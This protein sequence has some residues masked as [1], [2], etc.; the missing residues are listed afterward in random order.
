M[1]AKPKRNAV[2]LLGRCA[3]K[4]NT[5]QRWTITKRKCF[6]VV[7]EYKT[8]TLDLQSCDFEKYFQECEE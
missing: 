4:L 6:G 1:K 8:I 2:L 7:L 3:I 5:A